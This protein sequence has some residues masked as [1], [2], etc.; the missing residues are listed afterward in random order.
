MA[1]TSPGLTSPA[2]TAT[3]A[4]PNAPILLQQVYPGLVTQENDSFDTYLMANFRGSNVLERSLSRNQLYSERIS[5]H[6]TIGDVH[7]G[8]T[9]S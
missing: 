5:S 2:L 8:V 6:G 9:S 7:V 1:Y 3:S 4:R